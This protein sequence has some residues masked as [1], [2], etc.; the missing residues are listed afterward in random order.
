M[1]IHT[2]TDEVIEFDNTE[3]KQILEA[4]YPTGD[5]FDNGESAI[6]YIK[7]QCNDPTIN[8]ASVIHFAKFGESLAPLMFQIQY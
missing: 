5:H 8:D 7:S 2:L 1:K 6:S 4:S 3:M